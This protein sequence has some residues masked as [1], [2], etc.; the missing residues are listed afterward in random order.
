MLWE[1]DED[2]AVCKAW[3]AV[4][5]DPNFGRTRWGREFWHAVTRK[6]HTEGG[7]TRRSLSSI[8]SRIGLIQPIVTDFNC[9]VAA[10][11][12]YHASAGYEAILQIAREAY[13]KIRAKPFTMRHCWELLRHHEDFAESFSSD[14]DASE[15]EFLDPN[16]FDMP[17]RTTRSKAVHPTPSSIGHEAEHDAEEQCRP[18][19]RVDESD[20][21]QEILRVNPRKRKATMFESWQEMTATYAA[22]EKRR[23]VYEEK[24]YDVAVSRSTLEAERLQR[25]IIKQSV[26]AAKKKALARKGLRDAGVPENEINALLPLN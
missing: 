9:C 23:L 19:R 17:V 22:V 10:A 6:C 8:R 11:T 18:A 3:L 20:S 15:L 13:A 21:D 2:L 16:D 26:E 1:V 4:A 25:E 12:H 7:L 24:R 14:P 5:E